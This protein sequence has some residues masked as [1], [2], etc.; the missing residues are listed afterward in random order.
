MPDP[1]K[2]T[3][4]HSEREVASTRETSVTAE[5]PETPGLESLASPLA[6]LFSDVAVELWDGPLGQVEEPDGRW[7]PSPVKPAKTEDTRPA[8]PAAVPPAQGRRRKTGKDKGGDSEERQGSRPDKDVPSSSTSPSAP[9][10][11]APPEEPSNSTFEDLDID[12]LP[13]PALHQEPFRPQLQATAPAG[14]GR[15]GFWGRS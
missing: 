15:A 14:G 8:G 9:P 4:D 2:V 12:S 3:Q 13:T 11:E 7:S 1:A 6:E 5:P 10:Q